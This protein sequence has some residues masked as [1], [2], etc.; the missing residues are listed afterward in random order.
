MDL[1][2][3]SSTETLNLRLALEGGPNALVG[4]L[5]AT[6]TSVTLESGSDWTHLVFSLTSGDLV[7]VSGNSGVTGNDVMA[8]LGNVVEL[9]L[10]NSVNPDWTGAPV[11]ATL[12][13]DKILAVVVP[14][15]LALLLFGSGLIGFYTLQLRRRRSFW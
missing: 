10:L 3:L 6:G 1:K 5:F 8:A 14:L 15:P 4:G 13:I 11:T 7:A 2:N 9:R 12:G